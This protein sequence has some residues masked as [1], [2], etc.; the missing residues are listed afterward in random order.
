MTTTKRQHLKAS[1]LS[2]QGSRLTFVCR[3][4]PQQQSLTLTLLTERGRCPIDVSLTQA[5][6]TES[7]DFIC[8]ASVTGRRESLKQAEPPQAVRKYIRQY[9]RTEARLRALSPELPN[10]KALSL[11]VSLGGMK[12]EVEKPISPGTRLN[13]SLD[14]DIPDQE[15]LLLSGRVAWC[16]SYGKLFTVGLQFQDLEPWVLPLLESFQ[17]WLNGTG[18]RP[19]PFKAPTELEFPEPVEPV[20]VEPTPPAG[21]LS[22]LLF[23]QGQAELT[24]TW[25]R[26]EVFR[27]TF[28][29]V[30]IFRD[31]R[32]M[33]G[34]AF[35]D[36]LDLEDSTLMQSTLKRLPVSL[37]EERTL[38]HYRFLNR[39]ERTVLEVVCKQPAQ[40]R[41]VKEGP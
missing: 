24:L 28:P 14:L 36:A 33:E 8:Q 19:R 38:F 16:Q 4:C 31:D 9:P 1:Y 30:L 12:L 34:A 11:D 41:L 29:E 25:T 3:D 21:H 2:H 20:G 10:F 32:G 40:Y 5:R 37:E 13:L 26:G 22:Q 39:G 15:P 7:G 6:Q 35:H 18:L 17:S 23:S 27:V